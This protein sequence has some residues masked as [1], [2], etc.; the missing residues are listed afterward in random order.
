MKKRSQDK[1]PPTLTTTTTE[2][3]HEFLLILLNY[4]KELSP[5]EYNLPL[6]KNRKKG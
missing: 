6:K 1:Q 5:T 3:L 4:K 2:K